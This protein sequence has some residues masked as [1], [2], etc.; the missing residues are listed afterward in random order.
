MYPADFVTTEDG[1]G[2]VHTAVM[3]GADDF[4]LG[5]KVGLPKVHLVNA[6]GKFIAGTGL[7]EGRFVREE[8]ANG[9][10][11]LAVDIVDDLTA[12]DLF[13]SKENY[14]HTYPFCWRCK[15]P[16]VYYARDSWFIRMQDLR[17]SLLTANSTVNWEPAHIR[18][19][20]MGEWLGNVKDWAISRERYWGTP[21]PVWQGED[22]SERVVIGSVEEMRA[23]TKKSG[24]SYFLMR[25]G[26]SEGNALGYYD[27]DG[28]ETNSLT[29]KGREQVKT[30]AAALLGKGIQKIY[31]SPL[32]RT[33]E[34]AEIA[35][36]VLGIPADAIIFDERLREFNFGSFSGKDVKEPLDAFAEWK[37]EAS[38][39]DAVPGGE[40]YE[41]AKNRFASFLYELEETIAEEKVL[42]VSHGIAFESA[43][44]LA[45][46][47]Q[48]RMQLRC[49][50][51]CS[52][53]LPMLKFA[54]SISCH[55]RI[56]NAT[57][58]TCIVHT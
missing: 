29:D 2:I 33:K 35:A 25:H 26:E 32:L 55:F 21:L 43:E 7:L 24:N 50:T 53:K 51:A 10:P 31:A 3:Y 47:T 13:F 34:T 30:S 49:S 23:R 45:R 44:V 1:T 37:K 6:E 15:T 12:R 56:T 39:V 52:A 41:T 17:E 48:L 58:S 14:Q 54:N 38:Y 57:N 11:T 46:G 5:Q 36:S 22:G 20:R 16:L 19:G 28:C 40:S 4:E 27:S 9:K 8:D 42:I 18:E